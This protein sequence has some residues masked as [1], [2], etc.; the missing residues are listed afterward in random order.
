MSVVMT[1]AMSRL[2]AGTTAAA[3]RVRREPQ[4]MLDALRGSLFDLDLLAEE[5]R[6]ASPDRSTRPLVH[7][8]PDGLF[9]V[10]AIVW[11]PGQGS[12]VHGHHTWCA[13]GVYAGE[14][15][16][17]FY[18]EQP[19]HAEPVAVREVRRR[20][21]DQCFDA[22]GPGIHRI[23][24]EGHEVAISIHVYGVGADRISTGV[25]RIYPPAA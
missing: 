6:R 17:T 7:A 13:V 10:L 15:V 16:E 23:R 3:A 24:N 22:G 18:R 5:H 4:P 1:P 2:V 20:P 12:P 25:N 14:L 19:G 9:S 11:G 8:D 21:G